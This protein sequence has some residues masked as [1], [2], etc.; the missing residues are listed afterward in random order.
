V[1]QALINMGVAVHLFPVTGLPMPLVSMG[2]T[3]LIFT[4]IALGIILSV[5]RT[6]T[7]EIEE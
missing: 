2:G 3:S 7:F 1:I 5:S 4:S 6:D